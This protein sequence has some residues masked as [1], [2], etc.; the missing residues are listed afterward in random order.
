MTISRLRAITIIVP[1]VFL[2][3]LE[4]FSLFVLIPLLGDRAAIRMLVI[5]AIMTLAVV[6]FSFWVFATLDRQQRDLKE[7]A[8]VLDSVTDYAIFMLDPDGTVV[9]WSPGA[10]QVKGYRA[11]EI[12][13]RPVSTFYTPDEVA[14][15]KPH[16][17]LE[18][19]AR[20]GRAEYEGRRVRKD[21]S[22]FWA[23]V[24]STAIHDD[25]GELV[26]F[27]QVARDMTQRRE[28]EEQIRS[29]NRELAETVDRLRLAN[30]QNE[31]LYGELRASHDR[32]QGWTE[33]LEQKVAERTHEIARYSKEL[34]TRVLRAQEEERKRIARELHDDTGQQLSTLLINLDLLEPSISADDPLL[35]AGI[36]RV[37][38]IAQRT[39]DAVR[40]LSHDLRP[41]ILDDFGLI[42][43][44][45][46][47]GDEY[48]KT[49]GVP[50]RIEIEDV[51][52][53]R[54]TPEAELALFR[55]T[56]EALTNSGKYAQATETG[57]ALEGD[58]GCVRLTVT[59]NGRGF[60]P[61]ALR[62]PSRQGGLGLYGMRERIEL[63]GGRFTI[64]A[65][66]GQGTRIKAEIPLHEG[67]P[68]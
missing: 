42:A 6:P 21:G 60:D 26:G 59:D 12:L 40:A 50:V 65:A 36:D 17:N 58:D 64:E 49:F 30:D 35:K 9:T 55:V 10:E 56:Q 62:G 52:E 14:E 31:R 19:A 22:R 54:L 48:S 5:F 68:T 38:T 8:A 7:A 53:D 23:N 1:I 33:E 39:L 66:P 61:E 13:G 46:W 4:A 11:D 37:R 57:V 20:E 3:A 25:A 28:A 2:V 67:T 51:P 45:R 29:L 15:G 44:I 47:F 32:L 18:L 27:T 43:A 16:E 41:T 63:L 24:V 34:T